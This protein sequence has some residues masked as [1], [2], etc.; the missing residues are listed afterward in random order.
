MYS[1]LHLIYFQQGEKITLTVK[2]PK[3]K[4]NVEIESNADIKKVTNSCFFKYAFILK[5]PTII[6]K[7]TKM[8]LK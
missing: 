5:W 7:N 2:T 4:Q 3:E 6:E 8:L 1:F